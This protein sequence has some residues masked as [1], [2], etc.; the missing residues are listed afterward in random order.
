VEATVDKIRQKT[1]W[2]EVDAP[3]IYGN[4]IGVGSTPYDINFVIG[5]IEGATSEQVNAKPLLKVILSPEL[6][7]NLA[8]LLNVIMEGYVSGNGPLRSAALANA[9]EMK[10][11]MAESAI[12][13]ESR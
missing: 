2:K 5:E 9:D 13:I 10:R 1:V 4:V 12:K 8:S 7:A 6:A 3:T 11:R